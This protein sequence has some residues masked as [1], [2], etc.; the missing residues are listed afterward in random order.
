MTTKVGLAS[1]DAYVRA[2]PANSDELTIEKVEWGEFDGAVWIVTTVRARGDL[3]AIEPLY[4]VE[5]LAHKAGYAAGELPVVFRIVELD[6]GEE[7]SEGPRTL[8]DAPAR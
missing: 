5:L 6:L 8:H 3:C 2:L 1:V 7:L 4:D